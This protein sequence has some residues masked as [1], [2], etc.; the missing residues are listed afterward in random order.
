[1]EARPGQPLEV[2]LRSVARKAA[3]H[4]SPFASAQWG[5]LAGLW[6]DLGK[7]QAA[8][9]RRL[10]GE[11][12]ACEHSGL[13]AAMAAERH[14]HLGLLL[15]FVIA[16]HHAGLANAVDRGES[17]LLPLQERL[18]TNHRLLEKIRSSLPEALL[19][20]PLPDLPSFLGNERLAV[21]FWIRLL[22]SALVD[23]DRLDAEAAG[24][25]ACSRHRGDYQSIE[26]LK[27][28]LDGHLDAKLD[29]IEP[30]EK[31]SRVNRA[32]AAVLAACRSA[33][34]LATGLFSLTVPTGG[35]KTLAA[36][37]FALD[38]AATHGLRRVIV[39][40]PYTSIIEQN[41]RVYRDA[42][43][44]DQVIEHHS[45]LD[46]DRQTEEIQQRQELAAENWDAPVIVTTTVQFFESLFSNKPSRCRKLHNIARS[47]II[48]DEVQTLPPEFLLAIL[49]GLNRLATQYGC[50]VVLSTATPPALATRERFECGLRNVRPIIEDPAAL[51][52]Q[53]N[54]VDYEWPAPEAPPVDWE[55]LA[56][57]LAR[58]ERVLAV[59][60]RRADAYRLACLLK[61]RTDEQTVFHLSALMC[62]AH[63]SY[64]ID[65]IRA[66]LDEGAACRVVSTQLIEAGVDLDFPVVYRALGGLDSIVQAA[67]RCN[68]EGRSKR[69][70]VILFRAPTKPPPGT[71]R[72]ALEAVETML[73]ETNGRLDPADPKA[74]ED[75]FRRL[76]HVHVL[77]A[78]GIQAQRAQLNFANVGR[79]FKLIEDGYTE[80]VVV[81][82]GRAAE[83]IEEIQRRGITRELRRALQP[84]TVSIPAY[85]VEDLKK[86]AAIEPIVEGVQWVGS[87]TNAYDAKFG[88]QLDQAAAIDP[89]RLIQ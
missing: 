75:Y 30:A 59:V 66:R 3:E 27:S 88:L 15:A 82:W 64:V 85:A 69:G 36:M 16:G 89:E 45:N 70:K 4:A 81:P 28:N 50:T 20:E 19:A 7:Y 48:L 33:A 42:L 43:G 5:N 38:H 11:A 13:G 40:I 24:E 21:E 49:D 52:R 23:A 79:D 67:G 84:Y 71:P 74:I 62:P 10:A 18:K 17:S 65:L 34:S 32:R 25:A 14:Q 63:R 86:C 39:V 76:Y 44:E 72:K 31:G 22:F 29:G 78:K 51:S 6:H 53:L 55:T 26:D 1:M 35:G 73:K 8:F 57:H 9:Q 61:A 12:I 83:T 54:R 2:H 60:H 41:A 77:D 46:P 37:A 80:S 87:L 58:H 56:D 47:V 68:R